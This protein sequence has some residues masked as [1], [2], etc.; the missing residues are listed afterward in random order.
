MIYAMHKRTMIGCEEVIKQAVANCP[1][2]AIKKYLERNYA[3]NTHR[4]ALWARQ[5][6]PFLLQTTSTNPLESY[7]SELKRMISSHHGLIGACNKIVTLDTK[8]RSDSEYVAFEFR[9]KKISAI[10]IDYE[11]L[12]EIHKFPY[13]V[14][15]L[16]V[17][18]VLAV[19]KRLEK[20]KE[21]PGLISLDCQCLF[22][23]RYLLPCK[24]IFH[25]HIYG[26]NKLLNSNA[27]IRF[28]QMFE[29]SGFEIYEHRELVEV[30]NLKKTKEEKATKNR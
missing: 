14:Q 9:T 27:W 13:P 22:F 11:I 5:H 3:K 17:E 15:K 18:E 8:K 2:P 24:H 4:W 10:G 16:V 6:S 19:E 7:H 26:T 25:D 1:V 20:G 21:P 30:K 12:D 28:Q 29:D 23:R